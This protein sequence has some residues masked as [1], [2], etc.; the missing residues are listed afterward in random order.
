[1]P[2]QFVNE[3]AKS[4][5]F[6]YVIDD[7]PQTLQPLDPCVASPG[8]TT[9]KAP[10][11]RRATIERAKGILMAVHAIDEQ[12]AFDLLRTYSQRSG[13]R[14]IDIAEAITISHRRLAPRELRS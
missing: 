6:A 7:D 4:G 5:I 1:M 2:A 9:L 10:F 14:L 13:R 8:T 11:A 12:Q 3:A